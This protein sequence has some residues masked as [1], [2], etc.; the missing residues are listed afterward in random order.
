MAGG[1]TPV[2]GAC[3]RFLVAPAGTLRAVGGLDVAAAVEGVRWVRSYRVPGWRFVELRRGA[4]RAGAV[5][6]VAA[7][8]ADALERADR[9]AQAVRFQ[10]DAD[11]A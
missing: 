4:D 1:L 10:V 8:R 11:T 2:G 5:L 6:A 3:V 9:A 7:S